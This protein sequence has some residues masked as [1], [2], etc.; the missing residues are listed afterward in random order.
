MSRF[1][2]ILSYRRERKRVRYLL[3]ENNHDFW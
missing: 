1:D 3:S 2:N